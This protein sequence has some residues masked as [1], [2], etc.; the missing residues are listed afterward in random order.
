VVLEGDRL[1]GIVTK[2]DVVSLVADGRDL[3]EP[4]VGDVMS[5]E[6]VTIAPDAGV[7]DA[8][9]LMADHGIK[10][11]PVVEGEALVGMCS[12]TDL[13]RVL[14]THHIRA[15]EQASGRRGRGENG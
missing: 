11:L 13:S 9:R 3:D 4:T 14:P 12:S 1:V 8:A 10:H 15:I 7:R 6:P 2:S 5:A